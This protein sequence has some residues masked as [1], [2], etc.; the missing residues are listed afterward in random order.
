VVTGLGGSVCA[1]PSSA[2]EPG[3]SCRAV[4]YCSAL[5]SCLGLTVRPANFGGTLFDTV[6]I[7]TPS[8]PT[9]WTSQSPESVGLL[10]PSLALPPPPAAP[11]LPAT[12]TSHTV[13]YLGRLHPSLSQALPS[14]T[15][16]LGVQFP[17]SDRRVPGSEGTYPPPPPRETV[18]QGSVLG[19][20]LLGT[21][22]RPAWGRGAVR[23]PLF[24]GPR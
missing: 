11:R 22:S 1:S 18:S 3:R 9:Y 14:S 19:A 17:V 5:P 16:S 10:F 7:H 13:L 6:Q 12:S 21:V 24:E 2:M 8:V 20:Q 15:T 23:A 4:L